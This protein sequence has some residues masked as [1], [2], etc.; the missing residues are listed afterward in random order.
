M[1]RVEHGPRQIGA[2]QVHPGRQRA[3][4]CQMIRQQVGMRPAGRR[5]TGGWDRRANLDPPKRGFNHPRGAFRQQP[6]ADL[7]HVGGKRG[8]ER[9]RKCVKRAPRSA[10][11]GKACLFATKAHVEKRGLTIGLMDC[12]NVEAKRGQG[13]RQ[14]GP[15]TF[16]F[17]RQNDAR[18]FQRDRGRLECQRPH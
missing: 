3:F 10:T 2:R 4:R 7:R 17:D 8:T 6:R 18:F 12:T 5:A 13:I 11:H 14:P 16:A 1:L 9:P 15:P